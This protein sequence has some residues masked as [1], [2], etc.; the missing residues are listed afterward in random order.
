MLT[1]GH[2]AL[3]DHSSVEE[4]RAFQLTKRRPLGQHAIR[5]GLGVLSTERRHASSI[6]SSH[7]LKARCSSSIVMRNAIDKV[8]R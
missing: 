7:A 3:A 6:G 5:A 4:R 1:K 2:D 8:L